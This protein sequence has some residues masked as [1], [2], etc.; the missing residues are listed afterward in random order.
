MLHGATGNMFE[1]HKYPVS[2]GQKV[3]QKGNALIFISRRKTH[4]I[5][6][7]F[8]WILTKIHAFHS[9]PEIISV[10]HVRAVTF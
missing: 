1:C 7:L 10:L 2:L 4:E 6:D 5:L 3:V 9:F 8:P